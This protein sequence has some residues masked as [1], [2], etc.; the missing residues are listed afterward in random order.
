M[1]LRTLILRGYDPVKHIKA[2][3]ADPTAMSDDV[4]VSHPICWMSEKESEREVT[5]KWY[6]KHITRM[7]EVRSNG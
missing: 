1:M 4:I 2:L 7:R 3:E 5:W 6:D